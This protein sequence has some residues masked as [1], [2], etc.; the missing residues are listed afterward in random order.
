MKPEIAKLLKKMLM[1]RINYY[2]SVGDLA[3]G[4]TY[5]TVYDMLIYALDDNI[6]CLRQ[7]DYFG[8]EEK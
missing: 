7:F 5:A 4:G 2:D 3:T 6:E 8:E 1:D